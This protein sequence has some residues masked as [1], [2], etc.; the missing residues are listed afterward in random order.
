MK[1]TVFLSILYVVILLVLV[2]PGLS[3]EKK[4]TQS[5]SELLE[6]A[7]K[8]AGSVH[9]DRFQIMRSIGVDG[10]KKIFSIINRFARYGFLEKEDDTIRFRQSIR[11]FTEIF[12]E[13]KDL[14][15][16]ATEGDG[17]DG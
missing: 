7:V 5:Y 11:R 8:M 2:K 13:C 3:Q 16:K 6:L 1:K 4:S 10:D 14:E 15:I 17:E 12:K 9:G